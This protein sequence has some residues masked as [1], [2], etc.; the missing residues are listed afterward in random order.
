MRPPLHLFTIQQMHSLGRRFRWLGRKLGGTFPGLKYDLLESDL[1]ADSEDYLASSFIS[2]FIIGLL[3]FALFFAV[4]SSRPSGADMRMAAGGSAA[5][6]AVFFG[7]YVYYPTARAKTLSLRINTDL[8]YALRDLLVQV[9][10]GI[11]LYDGMVNIAAGSYGG[12]SKE[13]AE[14]V[15]EINSGMPEDAALERM[16]L[17][18]KNEFLKKAILQILNALSGGA[19]LRDAVRSTIAHLE[20]HQVNRIRDYASKLNFMSLLYML[21]AAAIPS[22]GVTFLLILSTFSGAGIGEDTILLII[23]LS[24]VM[25]LMMIGYMRA[26]R[27]VTY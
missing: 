9:Q 7:L 24:F 18:T 22:I 14:T 5:M 23:G 17:R 2:A 19:S 10:S 4:T 15:R 25:Q 11:S 12:V 16:A 8:L 3:M 20:N 26:I 27:P 6:F 21:V 1:K 13:F